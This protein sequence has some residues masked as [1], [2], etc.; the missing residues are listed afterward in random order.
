VRKSFRV[1][2]T[3][4]GAHSFTD[5]AAAAV[6]LNLNLCGREWKFHLLAIAGEAGPVVASFLSAVRSSASLLGYSAPTPQADYALVAYNPSWPEGGRYRL[7]RA[8][9]EVRPYVVGDGAEEV[10]E[11]AALDGKQLVLAEQPAGPIGKELPDSAAKLVAERAGSSAV[12]AFD[13]EV[14]PVL[15]KGSVALAVQSDR[16]RVRGN[17]EDSGFTATV[18]VSSRGVSRVYRVIGVAD[19]AGGHEFGELASSEAVLEL[20]SVLLPGL[21]EG[22]EAAALLREGFRAANERVLALVRERGATMASTMSVA[23]VEGATVHVG[24]VGDSRVY[25]LSGGRALRL[26]TDHKPP[27]GPRNV[28]TNALGLPSMWVELHA[29]AEGFRLEPGSILLA[30]TDGLTELVSDSDILR[31]AREHARAPSSLC[32]ELIN[33]ANSRG[34]YDNITVAAMTQLTGIPA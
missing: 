33:L 2:F 21:A 1:K 3:G 31:L 11:G 20:L 15:L 23:V 13:V 19:G 29:G 12:G 34:G 28:I 27:T 17:N 25:M 7:A 26:T 6:S 16:G 9:R 24:H 22:E 18:K 32:R 8:P 10:A 5:R 14:E 4:V 30:A